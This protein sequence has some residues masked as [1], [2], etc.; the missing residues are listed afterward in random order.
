MRAAVILGT[1]TR[2]IDRLV[3]QPTYL[4][5]EQSGLR[6]SLIY[7]ATND[8]TKE[9]YVRGILLSMS[10]EAQEAN[11]ER[12]IQDVTDQLLDVVNVRALLTPET[13]A[14][15]PD[16]LTAFVRQCLEL[17]KTVQRGKQKLEPHF[18]YLASTRFPWH[19]YGDRSA[20][21][22]NGRQAAGSP[23]TTAI[24]NSIVLIPRIYI[25]VPNA[26]PDPITPGCV[27]SRSHIDAAA[28]ELRQSLPSAPFS[29]ASSRGHRGRPG[30]N[31]SISGGVRSFLA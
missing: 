31:P 6:E 22:T 9:R 8:P 19:L 13:F 27:L 14:T 28:E 30:R 1:L 21:T 12:I 23:T 3:F 16:A 25:I 17:W 24:E 29:Q 26:D 15:F 5:D 4:L 10:P 2:L 18:E 11:S 20:E 7:E